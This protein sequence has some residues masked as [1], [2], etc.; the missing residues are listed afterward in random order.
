MS[1][2][3]EECYDKLESKCLIEDCFKELDLN[4]DGEITKAEFLIAASQNDTMTKMLVAAADAEKKRRKAEKQKKLEN[5]LDPD[6]A[7]TA[8]AVSDCEEG[9]NKKKK[10]KKKKKKEKHS[11]EK[12]ISSSRSGS[13]VPTFTR[14]SRRRSIF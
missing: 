13:P 10:K 8:Q 3:E 4:R 9:A 14:M 6:E 7:S 1:L 12:Y 2:L 5:E 11:L